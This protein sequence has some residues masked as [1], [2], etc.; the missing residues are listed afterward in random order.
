MRWASTNPAHGVND[1]SP[2]SQTLPEWEAKQKHISPPKSLILIKTNEK[3]LTIT[4]YWSNFFQVCVL[5][6]SHHS[7]SYRIVLPLKKTPTVL[8]VFTDY[9]L[10]SR[11]GIVSVYLTKY[12]LFMSQKILLVDSVYQVSFLLVI[13]N[14]TSFPWQEI[15]ILR[16]FQSV[17]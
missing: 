8:Q 5:F 2:H 9:L 12:H 1:C 17:L 7:L 13:F 6:T 10:S 3:T 15:W 14:S 11:L 4:K 16:M